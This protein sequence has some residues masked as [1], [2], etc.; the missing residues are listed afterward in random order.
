MIKDPGLTT[1]EV[2]DIL[3]RQVT[4]L[5]NEKL[6]PGTY[7]IEWNSRNNPSGVYL[8]KLN[9]GNFTETKRMVLIK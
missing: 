8:C 9:S 6:S 5:V 1:L 4:T 7:E 3:G 2:F